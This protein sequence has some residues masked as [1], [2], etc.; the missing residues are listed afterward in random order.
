VLLL[1][2]VLTVR[3]GQAQS[4]AGKGWEKF[5]DRVIGE[6]NRQ[7]E[8]L[9]FVLWGRYARGKKTLVDTSRHLVLE[10]PHPSPLSASYGFFGCRHFSRINAWLAEKGQAPIDWALD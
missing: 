6:L 10:A 2:T 1:N 7:R 4:H 3:A 5:T 9:V 8:G